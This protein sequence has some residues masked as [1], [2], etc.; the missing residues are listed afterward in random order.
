M[1]NQL[2]LILT[3][4]NEVFYGTPDEIVA[5]I[6]RTAFISLRDEAEFMVEWANRAKL[7]T[8]MPISADSAEDFIKTNIEAGFMKAIDQEGIQ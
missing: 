2:R 8:K 6:R 5:E 7:F 4:T 1:T 3:L